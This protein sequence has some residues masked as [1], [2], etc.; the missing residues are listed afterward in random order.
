MTYQTHSRV[1][2]SALPWQACWGGCYRHKK[3]GAPGA[4]DPAL[5]AE[6]GSARKRGQVT[7]VA[8]GAPIWTQLPTPAPR[9]RKMIAHR[10]NGGWKGKESGVPWGRHRILSWNLPR[11]SQNRA[12]TG[13]PGLWESAR[14]GH[15]AV[16]H[17]NAVIYK[18]TSIT[19]DGR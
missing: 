7:K 1:P 14:M 17:P 4:A 8:I 18:C 13:H 2:T 9:A 6:Y 12:R 15:P 11:P 5:Q 10:F 3:A 19:I 16:P